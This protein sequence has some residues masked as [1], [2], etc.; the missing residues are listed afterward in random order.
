MESVVMLSHTVAKHS[1]LIDR[2][3]YRNRSITWNLCILYRCF[4]VREHQWKTVG[5]VIRT[6]SVFLWR[7]DVN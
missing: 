3:Q 6:G 2:V 4:L 7:I 1:E 5:V